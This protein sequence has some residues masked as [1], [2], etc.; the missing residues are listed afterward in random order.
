MWFPLDFKSRFSLFRG[1][2]QLSVKKRCCSTSKSP[3]ADDLRFCSTVNRLNAGAICRS[4]EID[5]RVTQC[6]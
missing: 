2:Q 3:V 5:R 4:E 6:Q 1:S